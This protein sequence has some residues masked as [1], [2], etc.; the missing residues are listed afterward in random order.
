MNLC[1][2]FFNISRGDA[3]TTSYP[4]AGR[5]GADAGIP[6]QNISII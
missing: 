4:T 2:P 1:R 5:E 6:P 3:A